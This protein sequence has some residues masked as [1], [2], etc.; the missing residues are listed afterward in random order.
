MPLKGKNS[1][2]TYAPSAIRRDKHWPFP[3]KLTIAQIK[4][5]IEYFKNAILQTNLDL[6]A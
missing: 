4:K 5:L 2:Q 3:K 1:W 6:I